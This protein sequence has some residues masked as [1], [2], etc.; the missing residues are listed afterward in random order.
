MNMK[1]LFNNEAGVSPI[2]AT[3][4]LVV[5]A[6]A[7]AAAVGTILGSFSSDVS[8]DAS[9]D[10][11]ALGASAELLV[12][13]STTVQ[14]V[15]ELLAKKFMTENPG[16]KVTVQAGG[17][18]AGINAVNMGVVDIGA[19][20]E[21]VDTTVKF[22]ALKKHQIGA[23]AVV[24][25]GKNVNVKANNTL[26]A[27]N[28]LA[29]YNAANSTGMVNTTFLGNNNID[30]SAP[31]VIFKRSESGSGTAETF[32][33]YLTSSTTKSKTHIDGTN[34]LGRAGNAL[35]LNAVESSTVPAI[36][37]VDVGFTEKGT[38]TILPMD[39]MP[40]AKASYKDVRADS[41]KALKGDSTS[42]FPTLLTRPLIYLTNGEP[43]TLEKSF[44]EFATQPGQKTLFNDVGY[45]SMYDIV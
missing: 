44:I 14:P 5:V 41:I 21:D 25:I 3:L 27:A 24:L 17:S 30:A 29:I 39:S 43:S 1:K 42:T 36:G 20:S 9:A 15:S 23:S 7:G 18:T 38:V 13:G 11:A 40:K 16:I 28:V 22:P 32:S 34:A 45:F 26:T 4:V 33:Y 12:A 19:S 6:I 2:V 10:N 37:F 35:V 8:Q 31:A